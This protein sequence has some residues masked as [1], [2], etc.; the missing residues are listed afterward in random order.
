MRCPRLI[1]LPPPPEGKTGW[2]WTEESPQLPDVMPDGS[3]W[4]RISI[5]TP[6]FNQG[7]YIEETIRSVLLQGYA[8]LEYFVIDGGSKDQSLDVIS[9]YEPWLAYWETKPDKGQAHAINKGFRKASGEIIAWINSDDFYLRGA[10]CKAACW[11]R[12]GEDVFFIYGGC[13][14]VDEGGKVVDYYMGRHYP[15]QD[16]RSYWNH[17]VPQP[18]AFLLRE[19]LDEVGYLDESLNFVMDYDFW[20]RCSRSHVL[21]YTGEISSAFRVHRTSKTVALKAHFDPELD[22]AVRR[23]WGKPL[24]PTYIQYLLKRNRHRSG[25]FRW[26]AYEALENGNA[27]ASMRFIWR[28]V[29]QDPFFFLSTKFLSTRSLKHRYLPFLR[30]LLVC[31]AKGRG[32]SLPRQERDSKA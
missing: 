24:S 4:P 29:L 10:L 28:A 5:V 19:I 22:G 16:F 14:V 15:D 32:S 18:S 8:D 26:H 7:R 30:H 6:S 23:Y 9:R 21:F 12:R 17:Y 2:P 1:D 11:L 13:E 25:V 3:P 20:V 27:A 31:L